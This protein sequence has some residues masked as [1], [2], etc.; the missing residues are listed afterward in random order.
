MSKNQEQE[1]ILNILK[2]KRISIDLFYMFIEKG[3]P[4]TIYF[5][6]YITYGDGLLTQEEFDLLKRWLD[7]R[8]DNNSL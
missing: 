1:K 2:E 8:K 3:L 4:Y 5:T 6:N 7:V